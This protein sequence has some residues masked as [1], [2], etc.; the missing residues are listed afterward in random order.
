MELIKCSQTYLIRLYVVFLSMSGEGLLHILASSFRDRICHPLQTY[1]AITESFPPSL[2][3][4]WIKNR[5][6]NSQSRCSCER[7][8][9]NPC[10]DCSLLL[11]RLSP[12][13]LPHS[14]HKAPGKL[15]PAAPSVSLFKF[16]SLFQILF[17]YWQWMHLD[18]TAHSR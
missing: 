17:L 7:Y 18:K 9:Q 15:T 3:R 4:C 12:R 10:Q 11:C 16:F 2:C 1:V 8:H 6:Q 5:S 13:V 14:I